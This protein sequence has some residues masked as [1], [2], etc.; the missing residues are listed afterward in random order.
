MATRMMDPEYAELRD[1]LEKKTN[2][3]WKHETAVQRDRNE[4][5]KNYYQGGFSPYNCFPYDSVNG[6]H[7]GIAYTCSFEKTIEHFDRAFKKYPERFGTGDASDILK[8]LYDA[9]VILGDN[10]FNWTIDRYQEHIQTEDC[11]YAVPKVNGYFSDDFLRIDLFR[12]LKNSENNPDHKEFVGGLFH[13]LDHFSMGGRNLATGN[14]INDVASVCDVIY[15]IIDAFSQKDKVS[16][17][18]YCA[19]VPYDTRHR[20]RIAFYKEVESGAFYIKTAHLER[21]KTLI[22]TSAAGC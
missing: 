8:A 17:N 3:L 11:L 22:K 13:V 15:L 20:L 7:Y 16:E 18:E 21:A 4:E 10:L 9:M 5:E 1:Y 2:C 14:D 12:M 19:T 6:M